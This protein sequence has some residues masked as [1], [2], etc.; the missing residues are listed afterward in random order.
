MMSPSDDVT[1]SD[2]V[3]MSLSGSSEISV[4]SVVGT[5]A[6]IMP[7]VALSVVVFI[8]ECLKG[9]RSPNRNPKLK[10]GV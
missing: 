6:I 7:V 5:M 2:D 10:V 3:T 8:L 1:I 4:Y 9:K